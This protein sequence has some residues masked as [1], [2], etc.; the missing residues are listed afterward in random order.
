MLVDELSTLQDAVSTEPLL[1][2]TTPRGPGHED[3]YPSLNAR[4]GSGVMGSPE[5]PNDNDSAPGTPRHEAQL[6]VIRNVSSLV[7]THSCIDKFNAPC[8]YRT[9]PS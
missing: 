8:L 3:M 6:N 2:P 5:S 9:W 7:N 4:R 1:A